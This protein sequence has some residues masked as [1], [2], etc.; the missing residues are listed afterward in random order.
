MLAAIA[1]L[2]AYSAS[3]MWQQMVTAREDKVQSVVEAAQSIL[4][5]LYDQQI[6]GELTLEQAQAKAREILRE[7][8]YNG[9]EYFFAYDNKGVTMVQARDPSL[10]E[11]I[12]LILKQRVVATLCAKLSPWGKVGVG[13]YAMQPP[14]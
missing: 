2:S 10:R 14:R 13:F 5:N 7:S 3:Q 9:T 4:Q 12:V 6:S 1:G 11:A 8:R